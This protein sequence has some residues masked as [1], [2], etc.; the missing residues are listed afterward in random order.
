MQFRPAPWHY[1]EK[2]CVWPRCNPDFH[3]GK[4]FPAT[5]ASGYAGGIYLAGHESSQRLFKRALSNNYS[6]QFL[7][8]TLGN[9]YCYEWFWITLWNNDSEWWFPTNIQNNCFRYLFGIILM[10]NYLET[11]FQRI[12]HNLGGSFFFNWRKVN[13][14]VTHIY[15][16]WF[17]CIFQRLILKNFN[18]FYCI[19]W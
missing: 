7:W 6:E 10:K 2:W 16:C 15:L 19:F 8:T 11:L 13:K 5:R 9:T 3:Y 1:H 17:V 14:L 4:S 12:I 18:F